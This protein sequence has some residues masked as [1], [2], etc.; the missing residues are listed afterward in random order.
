MNLLFLD[1]AGGSGFLVTLMIMLPGML[2]IFLI[3]KHE[4]SSVVPLW[5]LAVFLIPILGWLSYLVK[6]F[7][8]DKRRSL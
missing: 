6:Y 5:I 8:I 3:L 4:K 1:G 2:A 7:I